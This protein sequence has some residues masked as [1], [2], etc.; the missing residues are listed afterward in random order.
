MH[1]LTQALCPKG[2]FSK[3]RRCP[4]LLGACVASFSRYEPV[5]LIKKETLTYVSITCFAITCIFLIFPLL[6]G[7]FCLFKAPTEFLSLFTETLRAAVV[8]INV[9]IPLQINI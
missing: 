9:L 3:Y 8:G 2:N 1:V 5:S 6:A 7:S 4:R